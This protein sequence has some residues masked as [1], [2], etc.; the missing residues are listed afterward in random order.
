MIFSNIKILDTDVRDLY[1]S[2]SDVRGFT[3]ISTVSIEKM[4]LSNIK[5][6]K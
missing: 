5:N 2:Y 4:V 6:L 1:V 3:I